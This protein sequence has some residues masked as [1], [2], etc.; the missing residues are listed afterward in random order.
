[1]LFKYL[2]P[3]SLLSFLGILKVLGMIRLFVDFDV[4]RLRFFYVRIC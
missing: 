2:L 3:S 4:V 1:M